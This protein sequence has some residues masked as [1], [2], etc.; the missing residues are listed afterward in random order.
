MTKTLLL[1]LDGNNCTHY[2]SKKLF[3]P[4]RVAIRVCE[5]QGYLKRVIKLN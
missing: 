1:T 4:Y 2:Y 5:A 3:S